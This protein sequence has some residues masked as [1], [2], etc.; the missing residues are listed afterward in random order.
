MAETEQNVLRW[1]GLARRAEAQTGVPAHVL[2]GLVEI[3]SGGIEGRTSSAGAGG[4]TQF[5]PSTAREYNVNVA[6]GHAWSQILGAA[7]YLKDLGFD[8][9]RVLA[10]KSYNAGPG[11]PGAAGDYA[12]KVLAAARKYTGVG[13]NVPAAASGT[14]EAAARPASGGVLGTD[15]RSGA[16][17]ALVWTSLVAGGVALAVIGTGRA[18]GLGAAS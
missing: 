14:V 7:K 18:A 17:R 6:P 8:R 11:N 12:D 1:A 3:E 13:G 16:T 10:L 5:M 15:V 4:L 9:D 2:L